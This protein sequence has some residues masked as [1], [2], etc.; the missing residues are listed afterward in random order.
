M[1]VLLS[2]LTSLNMVF[3]PG[4]II[5]DIYNFL[6]ETETVNYEDLYD[7]L[8]EI[9]ANPIDLNHTSDAELRRLRF[10]SERQ[11]DN[12][13]LYVEQHPM[14][15]LTELR[16][17]SDLQPYEIRN[18]LPFVCIKPRAPDNKIYAADVFRYAQQELL[19]RTDVRYAEDPHRDGQLDPV[20]RQFRYNFNYRNQ[21]QF[22]ATLRRPTGGDERSLLYGGYIQLSDI[23]AMKR[24]V[25]GNFQAV[26]G[27]GLVTAAPF[28]MGKSNYVLTAGSVQEGL[29]KYSSVDGS[30]L[31]GIG[32][33]WCYRGLDVA[34]WYSLTRTNDSLRR[35]ITGLNLSYRYKRMKIGATAVE[36]IYSD[37]L[38]YYYENARY[39]QNYFRGIRQF[40]GGVNFRWNQGIVDIF[41]E[42]ATAQNR[43]KWGYAVTGGVRINPIHDLGLILLYRY[44]SPH[45]DNTLG[46]AYSE[47]SRIN[48]ENGLY[49]GV[50]I[51]LIPHWR[52]AVYGDV[53]RFSGIKYGI[54]YS[55]SWGYDAQAEV[56]YLPEDVWSMT[57]KLRSRQKAKKDQWNLR[58]QFDY[59]QAGWKLRTE[60]D[61]GLVRTAARQLTYGLSLFQDVGYS[62]AMVP[63]T[64]QMRVQGFYIPQW[65]NRLYPYEND[66]LYAYS[67]NS[68]YGKGGRMYLNFRWKII[69]QLALYLRVSETV[70]ANSWVKEKKLPSATHTDIHLLFRAT[71]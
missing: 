43:R 42:A 55:P 48:D 66:V 65:D 68:L 58:Y 10:L 45:F 38:R 32:T 34:A 29:K 53:F 33:A 6:S 25:L 54:P 13:L 63:I 50:D 47:T 27:Q 18:M 61:A 39:N 44:Y 49:L 30:G 52:L 35:H 17:I 51:K 3:L 9:H 26:F 46:Y 14:D 69:P 40:V 36:N 71:L 64:L 57:L 7:E 60:A 1:H 56:S 19:L 62:F 5:D 37:T 70:Y 20:Y 59:G 16:L 22:G 15:S 41:A 21:V 8:M 11:I 28:H 31:H 24:L 2:I 4:E 67:I 12:I 23:G